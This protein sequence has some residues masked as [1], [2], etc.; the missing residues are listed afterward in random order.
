MAGEPDKSWT[1]ADLAHVIAA[2]DTLT[3]RVLRYLFTPGVVRE[4]PDL[5]FIAT[6][7]TRWLATD[8]AEAEVEGVKVAASAILDDLP[9]VRQ[10]QQTQS[11]AGAPLIPIIPPHS[12]DSLPLPIAA[13][14]SAFVTT[15][16]SRRRSQTTWSSAFPMQVLR[17]NG[18]GHGS[19]RVNF[20]H[21]GGPT[22]QQCRALLDRFP[23]LRGSITLQVTP[24]LAARMDRPELVRRGVGL[25]IHDPAVQTVTRARAYYMKNFL[26]DFS[27]EKCVTI[28]RRLRDACEVDSMIL[29]DEIVLSTDTASGQYSR[30]ELQMMCYL[31]TTERSQLQWAEL[32]AEGGLQL[33]HVYTYDAELGDSIILATTM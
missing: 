31:V 32:L 33:R 20:V 3:Y 26:H 15:M 12:T 24:V 4:N 13:A 11:S 18:L 16:R 7:A 2:D 27:N 1:P 22:S 17:F 21:I 10:R 6:D 14:V 29:I 23:G 8:D 9:D 5:T 30:P 19:D 28:L 25:H